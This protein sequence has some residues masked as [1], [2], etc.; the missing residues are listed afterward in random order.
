MRLT[1]TT[2]LQR[3]SL[4]SLSHHPW[5]MVLSV[6]GIALGV[7]VVVSIDLAGESAGRAFSSSM[8]SM[9]GKA[10]HQIIGGPDGVPD[11]LYRIVRVDWRMRNCAPVIQGYAVLADA[12][13]KRTLSLI[14]LDPFADTP[15]RNLLRDV[16]DPGNGSSRAFLTRPGA[17]LLSKTMAEQYSLSVGD[18]LVLRFRARRQ[19]AY[20]AGWWQTRQPSQ[21][22][23][24]EHLILADIATAQELLH[25]SGRLSWIDL[26]IPDNPEGEKQLEQLSLRLPAGI[27]VIRS[28]WHTDT[29]RQMTQAFHLNLTAMSLLALLVGMFLIFNTMTFSVV[30][31]RPLIGLLRAMGVTRREIFYL[32]IQETFWLGVIGT[33]LGLIAGVLLGKGMVRLVTQTLN[34]LYFVVATRSV[35]LSPW[36]LAKGVGLGIGATLMAGLKPAHEATLAPVGHVLRRSS[37]EVRLRQAVPRLSLLGLGCLGLGWLILWWPG[38]HV[39]ISFAGMVPLVVGFSLLTPAVLLLAVQMLT[40]VFSRLAGVLGRMSVRDVVA[41]MSRTAIAI[42]ALA[43]AVAAAVGVGTMIGTFRQT[44]VVWLQ[45]RLEADIYVSGPSLIARFNDATIDTTAVQAF[46]GIPGVRGLN[47]YREVQITTA[48]GRLHIIASRMQ[49]SSKRGF[50]WKAGK[51]AEIW[52]LFEKGEGVIVSEPYAFHHRLKPGDHLVMPTSHGESSLPVLGIY[53]DYSSDMGFIFMDH[54][55]YIRLWQDRRI[56]GVGVYLDAGADQE[57]VMQQ[58]RRLAPEHEEWI[59][60]SN[61]T[62]L[63]NSIAIFDRTFSV[64]YVLQTLAILVA[65]IGIFSSLMALQLEKSRELGVLRA[66]GLTPGQ[67]WGYTTLQTGVM[68]LVAGVLSLPL[69]NVLALILIYVINKRSF[70]WTLQFQFLPHWLY[71]AVLLAV[72]ASI[73]AGL[74]PAFRM[75]R[76]APAGALREE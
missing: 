36:S 53:Y 61:R 66:I 43:L 1:A 3:A 15:F 6:I 46:T 8:A 71:Q 4:R 50:R 64:T 63:Q 9:T 60:Q 76:S 62:L 75:S 21:Q 2:L 56:S 25:M 74:Y 19:T 11:S 42:S 59:V 27:Q 58:I 28:Q 20:L 40:P 52:P 37:S 34:D 17:V 54:D 45:N 44:V 70:G 14:G 68:G 7:A 10:T 73:A 47:I 55:L 24:L 48:N 35:L 18:S 5:Q 31:R 33:A 26:I 32:I 12:G 29:A 16:Q 67:L 49:P 57:Q 13:N 51:P 30:Q 38:R 72:F 22:Q 65:F 69:G 23:G 41:H 39:L